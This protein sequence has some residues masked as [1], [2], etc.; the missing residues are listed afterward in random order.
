MPEAVLVGY[1]VDLALG[2]RREPCL[3]ALLEPHDRDELLGRC[4]G[5]LPETLCQ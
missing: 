5:V 4:A 3:A 2:G 1:A